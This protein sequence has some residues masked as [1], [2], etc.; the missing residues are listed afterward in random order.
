MAAEGI[1]AARPLA[2]CILI[3][4]GVA[5]ASLTH[6]TTHTVSIYT[7]VAALQAEALLT[8]NLSPRAG[9]RLIALISAVSL[10]AD[11]AWITVI[12]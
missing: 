1:T 2:V 12:P 8:T 7:T 3:A 5:D 11:A 9:L 10:S 4:G 6:P